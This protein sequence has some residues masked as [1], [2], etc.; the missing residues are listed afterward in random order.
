[1]F[2]SQ[3]A[4]CSRFQM[5]FGMKMKMTETKPTLM[6]DNIKEM[7]LE[8]VS[9]EEEHKEGKELP[10][11]YLIWSLINLSTSTQQDITFSVSILRRL[12]EG[13]TIVL[14][15]LQSACFAIYKGTRK[16]E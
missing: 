11:S 14:G 1:M 7:S 12:V 6:V 2:L 8:L 10:Y 3:L 5:Q 13:P 4:Y 16:V 9:S 15:Q